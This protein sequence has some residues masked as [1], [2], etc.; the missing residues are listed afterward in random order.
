MLCK[1]I[2][3]NFVCILFYIVFVFVA[4]CNDFFE[5]ERIIRKVDH[6][7]IV[8]K[9]AEELKAFMSNILQLP[10]SWPYMYMNGF[11]TGGVF[12]GNL[13]IEAADSDTYISE[14]VIGGVALEPF[15][16]GD[17]I[18]EML[19]SRNIKNEVLEVHD[20]YRTININNILPGSW[21]FICE[22]FIEKEKRDKKWA[23]EKAMLEDINGGPLGISGVGEIKIAVDRRDRMINWIKLFFPYVL[24][25]EKYFKID[26]GPA[27]SFSITDKNYIKSIRF[28]VKSL[29]TARN[30]LIANNILGRDDKNIVS[31]DP[32]K[33]YGV[34]FEFS[35]PY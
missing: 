4:G 33:T 10:E 20:Q 12:A 3:K 23:K 24:Q 25:K 2:R 29:S 31:T 22:Y 6:V 1:L 17:E 5:E 21:I 11:Y 32:I 8:T 26:D 7:M 28:D 19:N 9:E 13:R 14:N 15:V 35:E 27:I 16:T 30:Y 34:L 18:I